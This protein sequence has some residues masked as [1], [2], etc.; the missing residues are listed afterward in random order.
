MIMKP[1]NIL[2][3]ACFLIGISVLHAQTNT[4][5][6]LR[7]AEKD[8]SKTGSAMMKADPPLSEAGNQRAQHL[9]QVLESY[10]PDLIY[11]TNYIRTKSTIAP[12]AKKF[13]KEIELYDP[14]KQGAFAEKLLSENGKTIVIAGHSNT[15][16]ALANL[17]IRENKYAS[18]DE[19]VYNQLWVIQ[20]R[21]GKIVSDQV[22]TY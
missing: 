3:I 8:T 21:G 18:L 5:I 13:G 12:L 10:R 17:L 14:A 2:L 19:S 6:L 11:S 15:I 4:Y 22:I 16:P 20:I 9:V 1:G 7:H